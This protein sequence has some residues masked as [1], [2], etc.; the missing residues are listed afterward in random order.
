MHGRR[1]TEKVN[2]YSTQPKKNKFISD[3]FA[4]DVLSTTLKSVLTIEHLY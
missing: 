1:I 3:Q 4:C 2:K